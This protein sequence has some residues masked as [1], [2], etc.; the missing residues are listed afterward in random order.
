MYENQKRTPVFYFDIGGVIVT[1][2]FSETETPDLK[3]RI[4]DILTESYEERFQKRIQ[5]NIHI[6]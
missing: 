6:V 1:V 3:T 4:R 2:E 5:E